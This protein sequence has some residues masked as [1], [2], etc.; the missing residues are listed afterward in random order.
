MKMSQNPTMDERPKDDDQMDTD[1][2]FDER[3]Q[4]ETPSKG[5]GPLKGTDTQATTYAE[6]LDKA[7][8]T[9]M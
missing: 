9:T 3:N 2:R 8:R 1:P 6:D 5:H 4:E 7:K